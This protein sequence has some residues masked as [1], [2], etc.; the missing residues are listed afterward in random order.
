MTEPAKLARII[1]HRG[2]SADAPENTLAA[3]ELAARQGAKC[4]EL[5]V[6]ISSD[7]IP[8]VHHDDTLERCTN[9]S[10]YLCA[11]TA[12]QLDKFTAANNHSGFNN[13]PIPRLSTTIDRL[14]QLNLG[15]NLEIKPTP[16]LEI[17]TTTAICE[18]IKTYWKSDLP[19]LLSSFN[20]EALA[21]ARDLLPGAP[22]ALI[23]CAV[24]SNWRQLTQQLLCS[25]L[26]VAAELL[27]EEQAEAVL[28]A[29]LGLYCF[30]VNDVEQAKRLFDMGVHGVFT[31]RPKKLL[32]AL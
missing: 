18:T 21:L 12:A 3:F 16:G 30:T 26:H 15:L 29:S 25:N 7:Q 11:H 5:D 8:F 32:T 4:V 28:D 10:G 9:G 2:A 14:N 1:A 13:E 23:V 19:L 6:S 24:P 17:E 20:Q 31:D 22:R 27:K